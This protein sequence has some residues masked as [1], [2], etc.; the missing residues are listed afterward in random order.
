M[1]RLRQILV[2]TRLSFEVK[3]GGNFKNNEIY[4]PNMFKIK[5][6]CRKIL[7]CI[8][9]QQ[10]HCNKKIVIFLTVKYCEKVYVGIFQAV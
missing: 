10:K 8:P 7:T 5:A 6:L 1:K 2:D 4:C 3:F 9:D